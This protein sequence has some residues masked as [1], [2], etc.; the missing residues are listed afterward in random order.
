MLEGL[1]DAMA[2]EAMFNKEQEKFMRHALGS[3]DQPKRRW[4]TRTERPPP[5]GTLRETRP[6]SNTGEERTRD[7][8]NYSLSVPFAI[9]Y[10]NLTEEC[11]ATLESRFNTNSY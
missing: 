4:A 7:F 2:Q 1:G 5:G 11:L 8:P 9:P 10:T 3:K 6:S